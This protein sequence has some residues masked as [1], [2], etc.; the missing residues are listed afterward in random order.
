MTESSRQ[1]GR[2]LA[3]GLHPAGAALLAQ[4]YI[5]LHWGSIDRPVIAGYE[6]RLTLF[7]L[8]VWG[9]A[10]FFV[11]RRS[12]RAAASFGLG[13]ALTT[14]IL[15]AAANWNNGVIAAPL[16]STALDPVSWRELAAA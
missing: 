3:A 16:E 2:A 14:F 13:A 1:P 8:A 7:C 10:G 11:A 15:L 12:D 5:L 9:L 4:T 6:G